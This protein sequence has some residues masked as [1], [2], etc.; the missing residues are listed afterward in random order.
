MAAPKHVCITGAS[1]GLGRAMAS[2]FVDLGWKV[3]GCGSNAERL[4]PLREAFPDQH[5]SVCDV[6][7][8]Q[9]AAAWVDSVVEEAGCPDLVLN[10][11]ALINHPAPVWEAPVEEVERIVDVNIKG[12]LWVMQGFL[13]RMVERGSG[14]VIN[15][16]SGWGRSTSPGVALY[17]TTKWAIEGL[18]QAAAQDLPDG[19]ACA[20]LNPGIIATDMLR[21]AFGAGAS[22]YPSPE[23][24][25]RAV[26]PYLAA[27]DPS[28]N[29]QP[30]TAPSC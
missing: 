11:A 8:P 23:T 15:F 4:A 17:C 18:C 27:L 5:W 25:S 24:W 19:V 2:G 10:N 14:I 9:A 30:L 22:S 13:P 3:S 6:S 7:N 26:V 20:A 16:S 28:V 21:E 1:R 12:V 29:G